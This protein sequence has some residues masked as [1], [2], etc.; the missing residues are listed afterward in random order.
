MKTV[1]K[2]E[3]DKFTKLMGEPGPNEELFFA[4]RRALGLGVGLDENGQMLNM[5]GPVFIDFEA[6][7]LSP[8]SWPIEVG[9]AAC[10]T[11]G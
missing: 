3:V 11:P 10:R 6:S 5:G 4:R 2:E 7:F 9:F 8:E 1:D